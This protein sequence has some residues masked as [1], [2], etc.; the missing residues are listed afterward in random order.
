MYSFPFKLKKNYLI[1]FCFIL[2][3]VPT[4]LFVWVPKSSEHIV[5]FSDSGFSPS[6]ITVAKGDKIIFKNNSSQDFWPASDPHPIHSNYSKF[7]PKKPVPAGE[8]WTFKA[9]TIGVWAFHDHMFPSFRGKLTVLSKKDFEMKNRNLKR[10]EIVKMIKDDP[11]GTYSTLKS[12]YDPSTSFAHSVFHLFGEVLYDKFGVDAI[13]YCDS[14]AGFGCF[15]GFFIRA[16]GEKGV[17][18]AVDLDKKC[19]ETFGPTGLGCP[20]GIG[21]GLVEYFGLGKL[22]EPLEVCQK[23]SW[24]GPLFGCAGG[25]FMENNFPTIFDKDGVGKVTTREPHGS[26]FEPCLSK[27]DG[28]FKPACYFEQASW[29]NEILKGN[30]EQIGKYC[31]SI[32]N[33]EEKES[34]LLGAGNS[35]AETSHYNAT[36]VVDECTHMIDKKSE[37]ICRAGGAWAFF[38][39]PEKRSESENIC[40]GLGAY[41]TLCLEKRILVK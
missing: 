34:C 29:W 31:G 3:I 6:V 20:H 27:T 11:A 33:P 41:E 1:L 2:L 26:L 28:K 37:A 32:K 10:E 36:K 21:H 12:I 9:N 16:V 14:F 35:L 24:Q 30:F 39:N 7:D 25:V 15:H 19:V 13:S 22:K 8:S 17:G 5:E 40:S 23:L 18:I 38:A 4:S